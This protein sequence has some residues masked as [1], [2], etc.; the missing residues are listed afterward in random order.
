MFSSEGPASQASL[1]PRPSDYH[2]YWYQDETGAWYNEYDDLGYQF[3]EDDD[4]LLMVAPG[5]PG[6]QPQS[7]KK[8]VRKVK[9]KQKYFSKENKFL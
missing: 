2:D 8:K 4:D 6:A 5:A 3:A 7:G 1:P 9:Q